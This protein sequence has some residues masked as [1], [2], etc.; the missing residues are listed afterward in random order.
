MMKVNDVL[1]RHSG[2]KTIVVKDLDAE[3]LLIEGSA[4]AISFLAELLSA[5]AEAGDCGLEISP[6]GPGSAF[7]APGSTKGIYVHITGK[8]GHS[9]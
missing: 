3:T 9:R 6:S 5:Q 7:F 4:E 1:E 2:S 8:C